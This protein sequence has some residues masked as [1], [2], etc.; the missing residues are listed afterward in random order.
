M[1]ITMAAPFPIHSNPGLGVQHTGP[2]C[3]LVA[4]SLLGQGTPM[5][6]GTSSIPRDFPKHRPPAAH[7]AYALGTQRV[8]TTVEVVLTH[9][10][11]Q[12]HLPQLPSPQ[13]QCWTEAGGWAQPGQMP[14]HSQHVFICHPVWH[15]RWVTGMGDYMLGPVSSTSTC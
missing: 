8:G 12:G 5:Q 11:P 6:L 3:P 14:A 7:A 13:N 10:C 1:L 15:W 9:H 2:R 4:S